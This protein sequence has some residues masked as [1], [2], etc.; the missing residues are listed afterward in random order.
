VTAEVGTSTQISCNFSREELG[1]VY[2]IIDGLIYNLY[3]ESYPLV[4][5]DSLYGEVVLS[6][7]AC[8]NGTTFQCLSGDTLYYGPVTT[9][10]VLE[11]MLAS[12]IRLNQYIFS[13]QELIILLSMLIV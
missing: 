9:L 12:Y 3:I 8:H 6:V 13:F 2:W 1:Q 4:H 7:Q 5:Q 11:G 10:H